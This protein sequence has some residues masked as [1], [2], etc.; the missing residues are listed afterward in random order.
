MTT[1]EQSNKRVGFTLIELLIVIG[2]AGVLAVLIIPAFSGIGRSQNMR[3]SVAQLRTTI[4]LA[5]QWAITHNEKTYVIFPDDEATYN[6]KGNVT[7]AFRS[8]GVWAEKSGYISEW[9]YLPEGIVFDPVAEQIGPSTATANLFKGVKGANGTIF[10]VQFPA[11]GSPTQE[12]YAISFTRN[13]RLNQNGGLTPQVFLR[14]GWV[15]ADTNNGT[16]SNPKFKPN[17]TYQMYFEVRPLTG[18]V[19]IGER[20]AAAP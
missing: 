8:Y 20:N 19:R 17:S 11:N 9:R 16:A 3:S 1:F 15:D 12:M 2:I 6:P 14:E 7:M 13:G 4:A 5:R 18:G 10:D